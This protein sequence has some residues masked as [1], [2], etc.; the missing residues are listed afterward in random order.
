MRTNDSSLKKIK[1]ISKEG[2]KIGYDPVLAWV[3]SDGK[4]GEE[5]PSTTFLNYAG[6]YM[7]RSGWRDNGMFLFFR[8]GPQGIGHVEQEKLQIVLKAWGK[9]LLFDPGKFFN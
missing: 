7:M 1:E 6:F 8:G 4:E 3:V 5:L 9:T 2:L